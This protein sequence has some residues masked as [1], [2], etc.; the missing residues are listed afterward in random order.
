ML[1][2]VGDIHHDVPEKN[3]VDVPLYYNLITQELFVTFAKEYFGNL[4][5]LNNKDSSKD[6]YWQ[7][8]ELS[9]DISDNM[10]SNHSEIIGTK[11]ANNVSLFKVYLTIHRAFPGSKDVTYGISLH[12]DLTQLDKLDDYKSLAN[13]IN[14]R[15]RTR[16]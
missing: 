13:F 15:L 14:L 9:Q 6:P 12:I 2:F 8:Y 4:E 16:K 3:I 10:F 11:H 5:S 1:C 7:L